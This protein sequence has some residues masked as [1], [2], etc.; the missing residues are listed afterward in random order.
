MASEIFSSLENL[1]TIGILRPFVYPNMYKYDDHQFF[2]P[3][4]S[5]LSTIPNPNELESSY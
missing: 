2:N 1:E 4:M 5:K 3:Y